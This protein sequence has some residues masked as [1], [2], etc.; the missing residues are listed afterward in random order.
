MKNINMDIIGY[1]KYKYG[2]IIGYK[3]YK[4]RYIT[5]YKRM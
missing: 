3:K 4:Y 1:E 2:Y 5:G